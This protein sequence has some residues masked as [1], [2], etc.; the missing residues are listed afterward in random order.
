MLGKASS[1]SNEYRDSRMGEVNQSSQD[2][3]KLCEQ[4]EEQKGEES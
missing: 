2:V 3:K 1:Y 4:E